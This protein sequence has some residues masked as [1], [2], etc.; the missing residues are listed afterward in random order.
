MLTGTGGRLHVALPK[1]KRIPVS[2]TGRG[3]GLQAA[4]LATHKQ[5]LIQTNPTQ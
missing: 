5:A 2:S 1:A 3:K 4:H